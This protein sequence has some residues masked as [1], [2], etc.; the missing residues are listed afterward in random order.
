MAGLNFFTAV[1]PFLILIVLA[2][3]QGETAG[4]CSTGEMKRAAVNDAL[5]TINCED[6]DC[7][8]LNLT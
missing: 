7:G 5:S 3:I 6:Y 8:N 1:S 4:T 2:H